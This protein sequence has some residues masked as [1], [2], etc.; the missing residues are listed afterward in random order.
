MT[1]ALCRFIQLAPTHHPTPG[2]PALQLVVIA[3]SAGG[4]GATPPSDAAVR[5]LTSPARNDVQGLA[6]LFP[7]DTPEG[8][9][10]SLVERA[11]GG[12]WHRLQGGSRAAGTRLQTCSSRT[13]RPASS[14]TAP[15]ACRRA[16]RL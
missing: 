11:A 1:G 8:V 14:R 6:L 5:T 4:E 15:L 10:P 2:G 9:G 13:A 7:L 16:R 12:S 3:G